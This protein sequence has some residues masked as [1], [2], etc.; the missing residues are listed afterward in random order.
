MGDQQLIDR[1]NEYR[2][3]VKQALTYIHAINQEFADLKPATKFHTMIQNQIG[4]EIEVCDYSTLV[5]SS[6]IDAAMTSIHMD[7]M[8]FEEIIKFS[9]F[10]GLGVPFQVKCISNVSFDQDEHYSEHLEVGK[11]YTVTDHLK[12]KDSIYFVLEGDELQYTNQNGIDGFPSFLFSVEEIV[13]Q[14]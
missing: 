12:F 6:A 3:K 5:R 2:S 13:N 7:A 4:F 11:V 10:F 14:N 1:V 9:G 8:A